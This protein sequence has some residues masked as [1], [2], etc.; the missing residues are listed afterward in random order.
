MRA[1]D[2]MTKP[3]I[4]VRPD[5]TVRDTAGLL[6]SHGFTAVPVVDQDDRLVGIVTEADL[7]RDRF[8]RD[9]RNRRH[10]DDETRA[11]GRA[12]SWPTS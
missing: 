3:V 12:P 8:P 1:C 10:T 4:T 5:T 11:C 6:A 7:L 2:I 9:A